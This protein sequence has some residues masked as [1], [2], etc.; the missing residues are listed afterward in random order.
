MDMQLNSLA[1]QI[2]KDLTQENK[3]RIAVIKFSNLDGKVTKLGKYVSEELIFRLHKTQRFSIVERAL[4]NKVMKEHKL[5]LSGVID[6]STAREVGK[7]LGVDALATGTVADLGR[8]IKI[9]A[10]LISTETGSIFTVAA[11]EVLKD[12]KV[13]RLLPEGKKGSKETY[14][15]FAPQVTNLAPRA[16][17]SASSQ[18]GPRYRI[19]NVAD[20][21]IGVMNKGEWATKWEQEGSW[22]LLE[23]PQQ[24]QVSKV[25]L[26]DR[27]YMHPNI[28]QA[29][30]TF[31]DGSSIQTGT[32]PD[33][34]TAKEF[35]F[36]PK[37]VTW[38]KFTVK[39]AKGQNIGL[40][41][42]EVY[43]Q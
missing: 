29:T 8:T 33:D 31:S 26:Y 4:L 5:N 9:N 11:V 34:G 20:G 7:I 22:L 35:V 23:W 40:S 37:I 14:P 19:R 25:V 13:A 2:V 32:L 1:A 39:Q 36:P 12:D 17:I 24:R 27:P 28:Q 18:L 30:L 42:I 21:V 43:G 41:E 6:E 16:T 3:T 15:T 10:R 38:I